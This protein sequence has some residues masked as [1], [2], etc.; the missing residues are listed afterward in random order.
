MKSFTDMQR[1]L[2]FVYI[3]QVCL[4]W[5]ILRWQ[6]GKLKLLL[7][8]EYAHRSYNVVAGEYQQ[9]QVLM[10]RFLEDEPIQGPRIKHYV[11]NRCLCRSLLQ[12]PI[13]KGDI[14]VYIYTYTCFVCPL[15][16]MDQNLNLF[17]IFS[18]D[19]DSCKKERLVGEKD[20]IPITKLAETIKDSMQVFSEFIRSHKD[21]TNGA[22]KG[23]QLMNPSD[24][25]LLSNIK[26]CL[27]KVF[28]KKKFQS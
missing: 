22:F 20:A 7:E 9:L 23:T 12:V 19:D 14:Y 26:T 27:K 4:S 21:G 24:L 1:D 3:G 28:F 8:Y 2:E 18:S 16:V 11:E 6:Y 10:H 17:I 15:I 25:E 5:E 13:I